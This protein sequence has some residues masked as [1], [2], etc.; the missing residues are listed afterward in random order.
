MILRLFGM[1]VK[2]FTARPE[3]IDQLPPRP[4]DDPIP[5][6]DLTFGCVADTKFVGRLR[7]PITLVLH[8]TRCATQGE[9]EDDSLQ[10]R[11]YKAR[12]IC[13]HTHTRRTQTLDPARAHDL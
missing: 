10:R 8:T 5:R 9:H 4:R 12:S 11:T 3:R 13:I 2:M 1:P 6:T 7:E